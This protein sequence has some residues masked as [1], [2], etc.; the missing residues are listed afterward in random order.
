MLFKKG[1][2]IN[3]K[4]FNDHLVLGD[5]TLIYFKHNQIGVIDTNDLDKIK[6]YRWYVTF[7]S[8]IKSFYVRASIKKENG[9]INHIH[10][11]RFVMNCPDTM[12]ID[13]IDHKTLNN[14]KTNLRIV[15]N[16]ENQR[17]LRRKKYKS[18]FSN[19]YKHRNGYQVRVG[20]GINT[21]FGKY[22]NERQ[23]AWVSNY[24]MK[25]LGYTDS[26]LNIL[27]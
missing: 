25:K 24:I 13:H 14:T 8:K 3:K 21:Y 4:P 17:N 26:C 1:H 12:I 19:V 2:M 22:E 10:I 18:K 23:A 20:S 7:D 27:K 5:T 11:H 9:S 15:T 16:K 6:T